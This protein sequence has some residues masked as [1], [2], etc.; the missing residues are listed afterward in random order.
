MRKPWKPSMKKS[1]TRLTKVNDYLPLLPGLDKINNITEEYI[2]KTLLHAIPD[3]WQK[4][5]PAGLQI[6]NV[7]LKFDHQHF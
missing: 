7:L 6:Q 5:L 3:I 4:S 2:N 1:P